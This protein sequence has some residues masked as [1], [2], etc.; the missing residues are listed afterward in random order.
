MSSVVAVKVLTD[1]AR[2]GELHRLVHDAFAPLAIDPPS[3][4]LRETIA[5]FEDRLQREIALVA[6]ATAPP[7]RGALVGSAFCIP[8]DDALYIGRLAVRSDFRRRGVASAL[9]D[10]AKEQAVRRGLGHLTLSTRVA[11][12]DNIALFRRH[13]FEVVAER[14]HPGFSRPTSYDMTLRLS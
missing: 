1:V 5:D 7:H 12:A 8:Q 14:G 4:A 6:E 11:L 10:A 9:L 3:G 13:G 2:V